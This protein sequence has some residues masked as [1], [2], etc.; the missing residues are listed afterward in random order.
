MSN[1]VHPEGAAGASADILGAPVTEA[2]AARR[3][4]FTVGSLRDRN[5]LKLTTT[6][7]YDPD[8]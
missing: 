6:I 7:N 1:V 3:S 2:G 8:K 5:G 4:S